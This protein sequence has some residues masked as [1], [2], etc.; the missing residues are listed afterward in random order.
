MSTTISRSFGSQ[1]FLYFQHG[2][3]GGEGMSATSNSIIHN[4]L[5]K[6]EVTSSM[7]L[8]VVTSTMETVD[9]MNLINYIHNFNIL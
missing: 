7:I 3:G 5:L 9:S 8:S 6:Q 4:T 2:G 1:D